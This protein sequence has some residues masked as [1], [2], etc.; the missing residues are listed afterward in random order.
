MTLTVQSVHTD[1]TDQDKK[2]EPTLGDVV[3]KLEEIAKGAAG[4]VEIQLMNPADPATLKAI[5]KAATEGMRVG[6]EQV[7]K[8]EGVDLVFDIFKADGD[9][10]IVYGIVLEPD[11]P[12]SQGDIA[13]AAEI[14]K[15]AHRFMEEGV[16]KMDVQ[17]SGDVIPAQLVEHSIVKADFMLGDHAVVKGSWLQG[18][19]VDDAGAWA[20][21]KAGRLTG[22]SMQGSG[23]RTAV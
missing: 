7:E 20:D 21:V 10:Q 3:A 8:S 4:T 18:W 23:V 13:S 14:E 2:K 22:F 12:D 5:A 1:R 17:H 15:A 16:F 19:R 6:G 11:L 9:Q